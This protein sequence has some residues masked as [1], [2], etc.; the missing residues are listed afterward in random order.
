M[1][2]GTYATTI[3]ARAMR[4]RKTIEETYETYRDSTL[5]WGFVDLQGSSRF[6]LVRGAKSGYVRAET[7]FALVRG[8]IA[9]CEDVT[10]IKEIGDEVLLACSSFR[11]LFEVILLL[12]QATW[13]LSAVLSDDQF[14]FAVRAAIGFGPAKR[15]IATRRLTEDYVGTSIDELARIMSTRDGSNIKVSRSAFDPSTEIIEQYKP[16]VDAGPLI[17][18]TGGKAASHPRD[19]FYRDLLVER[20]LLG[21]FREYFVPWRQ[22]LVES[23]LRNA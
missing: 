2:V 14:P 6:R 11:P 22:S 3:Q 21:D 4:E 18:V 1:N 12:D 5:F 13:Q 16:A 19:I 17:P 15:L 23:A 10:L 9:P 20:A 7:F 8:I